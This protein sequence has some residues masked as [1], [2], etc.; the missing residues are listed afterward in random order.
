MIPGHYDRAQVKNTSSLR[1][2]IVEQLIRATTPEGELVTRATLDREA[3][4]LNEIPGVTAQVSMASGT[5]PGTT[6][7]E[8]TVTPGK[9]Y[10]GYVGLD[11]QGDRTTGRGRVMMGGYANNLLGLGDQLR[12]DVLLSLIHISCMPGSRRTLS[13]FRFRINAASR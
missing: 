6:T 10:G 13:V 2:S 7:P 11:N 8:I 1:S 5:K 3:L 4:L 9:R 12:V